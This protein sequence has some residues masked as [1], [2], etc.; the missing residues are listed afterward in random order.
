MS[1][2]IEFPTMRSDVKDALMSLSDKEHQERVWGRYEPGV[3]YFDDLTLCV[4]ILF[5]CLVLPDP[6]RAVGAVLLPTEVAVFDQL[7]AALIPLVDELKMAPDEAYLAD[8]RWDAVVD[9]A[10]EAR[11][12]LDDGAS[13]AEAAELRDDVP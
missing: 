11:A 5:D 3:E 6:R 10:R 4:N 13:S 7:G 9:A 2:T 8:P 12:M 1:E